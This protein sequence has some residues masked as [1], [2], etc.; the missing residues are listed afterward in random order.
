MSVAALTIAGSDSGGGAG[1]QADLKTFLDHGVF[2]TSAI[3]ALT[4]QNSLG[5]HRIDAV[6][7]EGLIAQLRAVI[8]D[9]ALG[10]IKIGMLGSAAHVEAVARVLARLPRR[11]P[12]VVDPVMVASTGHRLLAPEAER[13]LAEQ[14]IPLA[15]VV[16]PNLDEA[17]VL[18]TVQGAPSAT[19]WASEHAVAVL[20]TGGDRIEA[21]TGEAT[22]AAE[23]TDVLY[24]AG[25]GAPPR[26]WSHPHQGSRPFHGT[27][28]TL[29]SA[30]AAQL[31]LGRPLPDAVDG[32]IRYV[33]Q[34]ITATM[35]HG[36][37]GSGN[38]SLLHG[39]LRGS[40][41]T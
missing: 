16:T 3:A 34:L 4:A 9:I 6:P 32:G 22:G 39:A 25:P 38:P 14:L 11:P 8:D 30:I 19:A 20:V 2:G 1:I 40:A 41:A 31:A 21:S 23:V 10:A 24:P 29:S 12:I 27:G 7:V 35:Q 36:S 26:R 37:V 13:C 17:E 33:Q 28:C 5:V 15:T 18:A